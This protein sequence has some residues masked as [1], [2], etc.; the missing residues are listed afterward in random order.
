MRTRPRQR[1][2]DTGSDEINLASQQALAGE[3]ALAA[4]DLAA[5][6]TAFR[7]A[8]YK[9]ASLSIYPALVTIA[10]HL[11]FRDGLAR[12]GVA[13]GDLRQA[14]DIY[15]RLN[16]PDIATKW[17][18]VLE[19]R[20]V[21][22]VA[23]LAHRTGDRATAQCRVRAIPGAVER[24]RRRVAAARRSATV[25]EPL[26]ALGGARYDRAIAITPAHHK[27]SPIPP[28][29]SCGICASSTRDRLYLR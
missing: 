25:P 6:D 12:V 7:A 2:L 18:S 22:A 5:A 29:W 15:R 9:I 23:R 21:L 17:T 19:P 28:T 8:E 4:G 1:A 3:I 27:R 11:P 20:Y 14:I 16:Q 10:N 26:V 24:C 13:R